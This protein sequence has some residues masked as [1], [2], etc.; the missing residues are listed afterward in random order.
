MGLAL[1]VEVGSVDMRYVCDGAGL[2][3]LVYMLSI[4]YSFLCLLKQGRLNK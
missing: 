3:G 4:Y 1:V 2:F